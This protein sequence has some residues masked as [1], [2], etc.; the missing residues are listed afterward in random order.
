MHNSE[1]IFQITLGWLVFLE[2]IT[3]LI[4]S[5]FNSETSEK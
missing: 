5:K 2:I 3:K 1:A 4:V